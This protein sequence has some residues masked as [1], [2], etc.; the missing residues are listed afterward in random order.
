MTAAMD[1]LAGLAESVKARGLAAPVLVRFT[2]DPEADL[3]AQVDAV[4]PDILLTSSG[5]EVAGRPRVTR[6]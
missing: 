2:R 5:R 3:A 6:A 4:R 1:E